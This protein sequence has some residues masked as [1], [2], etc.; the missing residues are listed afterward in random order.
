MYGLCCS[1]PNDKDFVKRFFFDV[2]G[3]TGLQGVFKLKAFVSACMDTS[4]CPYVNNES[5]LFKIKA[6]QLYFMHGTNIL[7]TIDLMGAG[8]E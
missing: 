5:L 7:D 4:M 1:G 3:F 2:S 8:Q 6:R